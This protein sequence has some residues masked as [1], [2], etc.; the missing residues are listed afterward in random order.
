MKKTL[1]GAYDAGTA[2][3][4]GDV[5][6]YT[7]DVVYHLQKSASAGTPPTD[8]RYWSHV[9]QNLS[10]AI[11]LML[12]VVG[13]AISGGVQIAN[14]LTTSSTGKALD[15]KQGKVLKGLVDDLTERVATLEAAAAADAETTPETP[16]ETTEE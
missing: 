15:A 2:Y 6:L 1:K 7:D 11:K 13:L 16:A 10:E 8:T 12:D 5:V 4:V 9:D 3:S 14:N